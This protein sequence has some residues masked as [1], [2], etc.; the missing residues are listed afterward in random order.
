MDA[1]TRVSA[2]G[3]SPDR[4]FRAPSPLALET[5]YKGQVGVVCLQMETLAAVTNARRLA[6]PGVDC[7]TWGPADL[8]FDM[9]AHPHHPFQT[10]EDCQRHVQQQL[11]LSR[12]RWVIAY[13]SY[14][15]DRGCRVRQRALPLR[16]TTP[17]KC[18][19]R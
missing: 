5:P 2:F 9:E 4:L 17:T 14:N 3:H 13:V 10:V 11:E 18:R 19:L 7:L 15:L 8:S 6:K 1:A 12:F 16:A